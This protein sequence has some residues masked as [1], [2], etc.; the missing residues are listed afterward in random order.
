MFIVYFIISLL[1]IFCTAFFYKYKQNLCLK[2][3]KK[4]VSALFYGFSYFLTDIYISL[5]KKF[6]HSNK[7]DFF[8]KKMITV[9]KLNPNENPS[10]LAYNLYAK[11]ISSCL[12]ILLTLSLFGLVFTLCNLVIPKE[13]ITSLN[14]PDDGSDSTHYKILVSSDDESETID[15]EVSKKIYEYGEIIAIFDKHRDEII[16]AFLNTNDS[17]AN[18]CYD[19]SFPSSI[20]DE[21]INLSWQPQ[22]LSLIDLNGHLVYENIS[23]SGTPTTVSVLMKLDDIEATMDI[24]VT[25]YKQ[26]KTDSSLNDIISSYIE[27]NSDPYSD[28]VLLPATIGNKSFSYTLP[29]DNTDYIF[30]LLSFAGIILIMV[31]SKNET[32]TALQKRKEQLMSDYPDIVSKLLL[33]LNAGLNIKNAVKKISADYLSNEKLKGHYAYEEL[34]ITLNLIDSGISEAGSYHDYGKRC[35]TMEYIKLGALLEQNLHSGSK[36]LRVLLTS[37]VSEA[38]ENHKASVIT[39]SKQAETKLIFPMILILIVIML[40]IMV[41]AF[42]NI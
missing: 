36:E 16:K 34:V 29:S 11:R 8:S 20:G 33:L 1:L 30:L 32:K 17:P 15:I 23:E 22:D 26:I 5:S 2:K 19:L 10:V 31:I 24:S 13:N 38:F 28:T 7:P 37:E 21:N 4:S 12:L 3:D 42:T 14:R 25:L 40:L 39:K 6:T 9:R 35:G 41:P 27:N 18:I